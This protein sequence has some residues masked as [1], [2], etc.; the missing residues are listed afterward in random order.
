MDK[1]QLETF[2]EALL[3]EKENLE[4]SLSKIAR[5][6]DIKKGD[7]QTTFEDLGSAKEDNAT[8][9]EQ[10]SDNLSVEVALEKKLQDIIAALKRIEKGTYGICENCHH[11]IDLERLKINPSAKTCIK[12]Q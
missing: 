5:P 4:K 12:C 7:Y 10:Y 9:M 3:K 8:E 11:E 6:I 1:K 2:K